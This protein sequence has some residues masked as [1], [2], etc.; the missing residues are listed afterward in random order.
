M[1]E[2]AIRRAGYRCEEAVLS[3]GSINVAGGEVGL[4]VAPSGS[5]KTTLFF[6]LTGALTNL[7]GGCFEGSVRLGSLNPLDMEDF[8]K[9]HRVLGFVLQDPDRQILLPTPLDEAAAVFE[10][11][12]FDFEE[13]RRRGLE[14][15]RRVGLERKAHVHVEELSTGERRRLTVALALALD[16]Q[17]L[18][19][20]EPTASLDAEG[21][22]IVKSVAEDYSARG[23]AVLI[24]E[25]KPRVFAGFA[26]KFYTIVE[27]R[28]A[29][30]GHSP[31]R[32]KP[33]YECIERTESASTGEV[34]IETSNLAV[35]YGGKAVV[36]YIDIEVRRGEVVALVGPNGSGKTTILKTLAGFLKPLSG[37]LK[38][39]GKT[40]YAPQNPDFAF[41][42]SSVEK[43]LI[44]ISKRSGIPL[45]R[46]RAAYP[47]LI[48]AARRSPYRLSHGQRR[49]L[50]LLIAYAFGR[51]VLLLDE[52]T[53]GLDANLYR[54]LVKMIAE[55]KSSGRAVVFSTH[56]PRLVADVADRVYLVESARV[57]EV[58]KCSALKLMGQRGGGV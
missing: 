52:P 53:T 17:V 25:H 1:I 6:A 56:D 49:L 4:V 21:I 28:I 54:D 16:P 51:D 13:A 22:R 14:F 12:G 46:L 57:K 30:L 33:T 50:S 44:D 39:S 18:I 9:L 58:D 36:D 2:A 29:E 8:E 37:S 24:A 43:E 34:V 55:A 40:F 20:D 47:W 26:D 3:G 48:S 31:I 23:R 11:Q 7:L 38:V 32:E 19:L 41:V 5:G 42:K 10:I 35:G 15:L 45:D 27:G